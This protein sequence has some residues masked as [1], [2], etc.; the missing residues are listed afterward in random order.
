IVLGALE[1]G[2]VFGELIIDQRQL[3]RLPYRIQRIGNA[4]GQLGM[5]I[6][7]NYDG[8][9]IYLLISLRN[10]QM[11]RERRSYPN[12]TQRIMDKAKHFPVK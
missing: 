6:V 4:G 9:L 11:E 3:R 8:I 5:V 7:P 1:A 12:R 10:V 2:M